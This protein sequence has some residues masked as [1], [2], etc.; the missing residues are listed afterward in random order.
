MRKQS[1]KLIEMK[2]DKL[3]DKLIQMKTDKP[4][5]KLGEKAKWQAD[6]NKNWQVK[7]QANWQARWGS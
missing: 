1:Y 4:I 3:L 5:D 7:W 2:S 6:S